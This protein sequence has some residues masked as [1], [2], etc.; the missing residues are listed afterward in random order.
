MKPASSALLP[1]MALA[2][3][4]SGQNARATWTRARAAA[5]ALRPVGAPWPAAVSVARDAATLGRPGSA[6]LV[7]LPGARVFDALSQEPSSP[8]EAETLPL[9]APADAEVGPARAKDIVVTFDGARAVSRDLHLAQVDPN[10]PAYV[11][12]YRHVYDA[13]LGELSA[14]G[15]DSRTLALYGASPIAS[16]RR[17][18][19][20][21]IRVDAIRAAEFQEMLRERGHRTY[22]SGRLPSP[23]GGVEPS[24]VG[25]RAD[26]LRA[27][28]ENRWGRPGM[29]PWQRLWWR[30][31]HPFSSEPPQPQ[32]GIIDD[33]VHGLEDLL[34]YVPWLRAP[35]RRPVSAGESTLDVV[36]EILTAAANAG[37]LVISSPWRSAPDDPGRPDARL[38]G[39]LASEGRVIVSAGSSG[40][41]SGPASVVTFRDGR[42]GI[43]RSAVVEASRP[44]AAGAVALLMM[45][46]GVT[47][48]GTA[49]DA[50]VEN[51]LEAS[52]SVDAAYERLV[53]KLGA[54]TAGGIPPAVI[55]RYRDLLREEMAVLLEMDDIS[56]E[57][58]PDETVL[59]NTLDRLLQNLRDRQTL[60]REHPGIWFRSKGWLGRAW[61]R[62]T[63]SASAPS[64]LSTLQG[65]RW[66]REALERM[67]ASFPDGR[68]VSEEERQ[69]RLQR[70]GALGVEMRRIEGG[71]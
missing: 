64:R 26:S 11:Q 10:G 70:L 35:Y 41:G 15:L 31:T 13:L 37:S 5:A 33:G 42:T 66:G 27:A 60:E 59:N 19:A 47:A 1:G 51:L 3:V 24:G 45:I 16:Y 17:I 69:K 30:A 18:N 12:D 25:P 54:P 28:A 9:V 71:G 46:F 36:L 40:D 39:A 63:F 58:R 55:E 68:P 34:A 14:A 20:A 6:G 65:L 52:M 56:S 43:V 57:S 7:V 29:T 50:I 61:T 21:T 23:S 62:M 2:L 22:G 8:N 32:V 38:L 53:V 48:P 44:A 49:L 67:S 4:L